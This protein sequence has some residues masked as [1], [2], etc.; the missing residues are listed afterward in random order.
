MEISVEMLPER[1]LEVIFVASGKR[2]Q[3]YLFPHGRRR[4]KG[5]PNHI[6]WYIH[7]HCFTAGRVILKYRVCDRFAA[8]STS[9][10]GTFCSF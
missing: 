7:L 8:P 1:S 6:H 9:G 4:R 3:L 10:V 2:L 5:S